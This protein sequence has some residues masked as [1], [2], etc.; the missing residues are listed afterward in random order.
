MDI[1][2]LNRIILILCLLSIGCYD[3]EKEKRKNEIIC[4]QEKNIKFY[5]K[6]DFRIWF[7]GEEV[8]GIKQINIYH[9]REGQII[10]ELKHT[11]LEDDKIKLLT[12]PSLKT[13]DS[14]R[15][16][17]NK[18]KD[19]YVYNFK[20]HARYGGKNFLGCYF[21]YYTVEGK[22]F[23]DPDLIRIFLDDFFTNQ[24]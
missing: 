3:K 5:Y 17:I 21:F 18:T 20:N 15:I 1:L 6:N 24:S 8:E 13:R 7:I 9:I 14:L 11:T 4:N 23:A 10:N 19:I 12:M 2:K 16:T 22:E